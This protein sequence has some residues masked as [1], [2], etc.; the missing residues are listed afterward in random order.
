MACFNRLGNDH[1]H[2]YITKKEKEWITLIGMY[3]MLQALGK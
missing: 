2:R 1:Q 3:R